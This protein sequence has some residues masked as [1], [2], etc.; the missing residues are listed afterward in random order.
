MVLHTFTNTVY[1]FLNSLLGSFTSRVSLP[2][3]TATGANETIREER[4]GISRGSAVEHVGHFV[5]GGKAMVI[6]L[7]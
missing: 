3:N 2:Q 4:P 5:T 6:N 7:A 1:S